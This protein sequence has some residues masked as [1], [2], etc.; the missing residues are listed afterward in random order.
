ML[1]SIAAWLTMAAIP[2]LGLGAPAQAELPANVAQQA[3]GGGVTVVATPLPAQ[4]DATR[5]KVALDTHAVNLD[6]YRFESIATL[7]DESGRHYA[8]QGV[9]QASGGGHHRSAVL[10]FGKLSA[11]AKT[12]EL[13]VRDVAGVPERVLRWGA[14]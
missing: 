14:E 4:G 1:R 9:E 5:I 7:R 12:V 3:A 6:A 2:M 8:L 13:V 10:R 11:Q